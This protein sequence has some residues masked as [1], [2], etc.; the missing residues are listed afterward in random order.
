VS[1]ASF[2]SQIMS[3]SSSIGVA[4]HGCKWWS[5]KTSHPFLIRWILWITL[6]Y[7]GIMYFIGSFFAFN[8]LL[9]VHSNVMNHLSS[10]SVPPKSQ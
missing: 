2:T 3:M 7:E 1:N 4:I 9:I 10:T 8:I 5:S 6:H